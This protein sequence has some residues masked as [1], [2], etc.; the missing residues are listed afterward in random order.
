MCRLGG[1]RLDERWRRETDR[2]GG[3]K[4]SALQQKNVCR[5]VATAAKRFVDHPPASA[6]SMTPAPPASVLSPQRHNPYNNE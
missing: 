3:V 5:I 2:G 6:A 4:L 1:R